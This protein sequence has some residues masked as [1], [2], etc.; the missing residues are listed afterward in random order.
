MSKQTMKKYSE[1]KRKNELFEK[2]KWSKLDDTNF[3]LNS[4]ERY[5]R[6][7]SWINQVRFITR[8]LID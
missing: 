8:V 1:K 3:D 2:K 4:I 5:E 6:D 7:Y